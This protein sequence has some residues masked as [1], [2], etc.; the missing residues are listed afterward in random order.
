MNFIPTAPLFL[1]DSNLAI[2][3][4]PLLQQIYTSEAI[5]GIVFLATVGFILAAPLLLVLRPTCSCAGKFRSWPTQP[6][7]LFLQYYTS[8][9]IIRWNFLICLLET[10]SSIPATPLFLLTRPTFAKTAII[11]S[12]LAKEGS[13][14]AS[15][16]FFFFCDQSALAQK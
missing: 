1:F 11:R 6:W 13:I 16:F 14:L 15:P 3:V 5:L 12:L 4:F 2:P 8:E 10:T 7:F 9:I